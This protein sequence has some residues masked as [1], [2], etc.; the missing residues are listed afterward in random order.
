M[1]VLKVGAC[2]P[3]SSPEAKEGPVL[4]EV[5]SSIE[6]M[7]PNTSLKITQGQVASHH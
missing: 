1:G 5:Q 7:A 3:A 2:R 4:G 6:P